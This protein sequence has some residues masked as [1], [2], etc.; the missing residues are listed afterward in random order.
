M[1]FFCP[2]ASLTL[3]A[4]KLL[5][6]WSATQFYSVSRIMTFICFTH[7]LHGQVLQRC[8]AQSGC[9]FCLMNIWLYMVWKN[10]RFIGANIGGNRIAQIRLFLNKL[11]WTFVSLAVGHSPSP[12]EGDLFF[13]LGLP[14]PTILLLYPPVSGLTASFQSLSLPCIYFLV[15]RVAFPC[16]L[17]FYG[18]H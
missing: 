4:C 12:S 17:I 16:L 1:L 13:L 3:I 8:H 10:H 14:S 5:N 15:L 6:R 7:C 18:F 11:K 9:F 2:P